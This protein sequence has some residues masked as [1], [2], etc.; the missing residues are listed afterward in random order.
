MP[1]FVSAVP[2]QSRYNGNMS[3]QAFPHLFTPLQLGP[4]RLS[5]RVLMGSMHTALEEMRGGH[6]KL[7][8]FYVER[9]RG[10]VELI[11]TGGIAPNFRGRLALPSAQLSWRWQLPRHRTVT[12]AV[13]EAGGHICMQILHAGRYAMHPFCVAPSAIRAPI[14][15]FTPKA[16]S[17]RAVWRCIDDFMRSAELARQAGYD[18]VEIMGSEGYLI[19]QFLCRH[20][21][22]RDDE[23]GG[24]FTKRMRF[25]VEIVKRT[26]QCLGKD[27]L[28]IYRLSMLDLLEQGSDHD[29]VVQ[30][31]QAI[32]Q[33]GADA[34]N[35]GIGWHEVRIP[36]IAASVPRAAFSWVTAGIRPHLSIPV[37]ASNRI[38]MPEV[39]ER[40]LA[41]G[42]ADMVS[43]ARPLLA[44][45][46]FVNK[47]RQGHSERINTCIAC[48]QGCL[49]RVFQGRRAS[50][51][52]NPRAGYETELRYDHAARHRHVVVIG[53][54]PAGLACASIAAQRG[55][56]VTA[57]E[58]AD[59]GG[60]FNLA[61]RIPGKQEFAET[62]RYFRQQLQQHG[63]ALHLHQRASVEQLC[64]LRPDV[65]VLASGVVPRKPDIEG[66]DHPSV[67]SYGQAIE[68][69][70]AG[71]DIGRRVLIIGAGGIG[72]DVA[73]LLVEAAQGE[74]DWYRQWGIDTQYR[75]A[76]AL[77]PPVPPKHNRQITLLQRSRAKPGA[78]LGKT[79]GWI[80]RLS[81]RRAGVRF[82]TEVH[83]EKI[84]DKGLHLCQQGRALCLPADRIIICS[85]QLSNRELYPGLQQ[86]AEREGFVVHIIGG[87]RKAAQLDAERAVRE[88]AE[89]ADTL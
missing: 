27:F 26:R 6:R 59:I 12:D 40:I 31:A 60:Q 37:I 29:E 28:V 10:G 11:V 23:W 65:V 80:H 39:A 78:R 8:A 52:V 17:P 35:T 61:R 41:E 79:T 15:K 86:A 18:G 56:R 88:G 74:H 51:L 24:S 45:A 89:L 50:C 34:I 71:D 20:S 76:G 70:A 30:L 69:V 84:D 3:E 19:N 62:L 7:A 47:A 81:L 83:Y 73:S 22:H 44:D 66:I 64:A 68:A 72:F 54:G 2:E 58:A 21:N 16:M 55:H 25:A 4:L 87:A 5:H 77:I 1:M 43:M 75:S 63:V 48:N 82:M 49:D 46:E 85:G 42:E 36:T 33:A 9:V 13:H 14:A 38:N 32:E 53:M 67:M 57:F